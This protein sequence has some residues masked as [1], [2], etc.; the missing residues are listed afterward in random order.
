VCRPWS[1]TG[2]INTS[3]HV[4]R[5]HG[6]TE[7]YLL[8]LGT[9]ATTTQILLTPYKNIGMT[10]VHSGEAYIDINISLPVG[11]H[12]SICKRPTEMQG[13]QYLETR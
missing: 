2:V 8:S 6:P 4:R 7:E 12:R 11:F 1:N 10:G 5:T 13:L 3:R 9:V